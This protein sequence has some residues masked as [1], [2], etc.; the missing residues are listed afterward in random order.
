MRQDHC[1]TA[2]R[3]E[4]TQRRLYRLDK[5]V[6]AIGKRLQ[7][8]GPDL[9]S[10]PFRLDPQGIGQT[11]VALLHHA[12][13]VALEDNRLARRR[14]GGAGSAGGPVLQI[15]TSAGLGDNRLARVGF[16][17]FGGS[18]T[19]RCTRVFTDPFGLAARLRARVAHPGRMTRFLAPMI[20]APE[21]YAALLATRHL[22]RG[23]S[24]VLDRGILAACAGLGGEIRTRWALGRLVA[25]VRGLGVATR[26]WVAGA[27]EKTGDGRAAGHRW[28]DNGVP[29]MAN[30]L[31]CGVSG[32]VHSAPPSLTSS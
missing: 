5:S 2:A 28:V 4:I 23:A 29:T 17:A 3:K 27:R 6:I 1:L 24:D 9:L 32:G 18:V 21:Q 11:G 30:E 8:V 15:T 25:V 14:I 31:E 13:R 16:G 7:V 26:W 10:S 19:S 12:L 22:V 20:A